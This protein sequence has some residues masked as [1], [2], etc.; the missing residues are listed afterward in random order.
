LSLKSGS[1]RRDPLCDER[2]IAALVVAGNEKADAGIDSIAAPPR[3]CGIVN[4]RHGL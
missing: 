1:C 2:S 4:M 3:C